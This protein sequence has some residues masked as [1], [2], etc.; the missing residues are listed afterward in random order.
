MPGADIERAVPSDKSKEASPSEDTLVAS[1]EQT[2]TELARTIDEITDRLNPA[3]AARRTVDQ[4][5]ERVTQV[6]PVMAG[7]AVVVLASA[8]V[9]YL[10][11]RGRRRRGN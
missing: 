1:I 8:A 3:N 11:V 4:V 6:D 10:L 7:G 5:K 9:I 2:R